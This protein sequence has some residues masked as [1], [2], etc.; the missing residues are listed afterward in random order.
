M[1]SNSV[2]KPRYH[3]GAQLNIKNIRENPVVSD[4]EAPGAAN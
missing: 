3:S 4:Q 1:T 2:Y